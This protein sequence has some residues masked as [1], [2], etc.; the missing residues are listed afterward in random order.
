MKYFLV[1]GLHGYSAIA[2]IS[3]VVSSFPPS[4]LHSLPNTLASASFSLCE[5]I[6]VSFATSGSMSPPTSVATLIIVLVSRSV[7]ASHV[8][9]NQEYAHG[10][11]SAI[12]Y[13]TAPV[14]S[15]ADLYS[16]EP[17]HPEPYRLDPLVKSDTRS[18]HAAAPTH[19]ESGPYYRYDNRFSSESPVLH[20]IGSYVPEAQTTSAP[21]PMHNI[22]YG[23]MTG[24]SGSIK[25][26][27][28]SVQPT[29]HV[30]GKNIT[31]T[32]TIPQLCPTCPYTT[33]TSPPT[34]TADYVPGNRTTV[35]VK[36]PCPTCP[37]TTL[38]THISGSQTTV[39]V[40][41]P[42]ATCPATVYYPVPIPTRSIPATSPLKEVVTVV[43]SCS[44]CPTTFYGG[45]TVPGVPAQPSFTTTTAH[46]N[47]RTMVFYPCHSC[48]A[49]TVTT[50]IP[51]GTPV[52]PS[53]SRSIAPFPMVNTTRHET[54][55]PSVV[56]SQTDV[57][58]ETSTATTSSCPSCPATTS[59]SVLPIASSGI[60]PNPPV[61]P[62]PVPHG[63][64][65]PAKPYAS[66]VPEV[67]V[68]SDGPTPAVESPNAVESAFVASPPISD[69]IIGSASATSAMN[70]AKAPVQSASAA[71]PAV[72]QE[73]AS[74]A[75]AAGN[76]VAPITSSAQS[77][78]S[79]IQTAPSQSTEAVA[80]ATFGGSSQS[81]T[82]ASEYSSSAS[83][84]TM[85]TIFSTVLLA[86]LSLF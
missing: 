71:S 14:S 5:L 61:H 26:T 80:T 63:E 81:S 36:Q 66:I 42:C 41:H 85:P 75:V 33:Y 47:V 51:A 62:S 72:F 55:E 37:L 53:A 17:H 16:P 9:T 21:Y 64:S 23:P 27:G 12:P 15:T 48:P 52:A 77:E 46:F 35:T 69:K 22:S 6:V 30:P 79:L 44:A 84:M 38:S 43:E 86:L 24:A 2:R 82:S 70:E 34:T 49:T 18:Y 40:V 10:N 50:V 13:P 54:L 67:S 31:T 20:S 60:P 45:S 83:K 29:R 25:T 1:H 32:V 59:T 74:V 39:T 76:S 4:S 19:N 65:S 73:T 58:M 7:Q 68:S 3:L 8:G 57:S 28:Q 78:Q 11:G 56:L